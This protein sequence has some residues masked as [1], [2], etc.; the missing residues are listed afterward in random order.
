MCI[1]DS[2]GSMA[3]AVGDLSIFDISL[4]G[5]HEK[6]VEMRCG[7][8]GMKKVIR[9]LKRRYELRVFRETDFRDTEGQFEGAALSCSEQLH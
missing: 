2:T 6:D 4:G 7:M 8:I 9:S 1:C 3:A 5:V